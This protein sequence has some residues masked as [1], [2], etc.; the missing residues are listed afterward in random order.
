MVCP[1]ENNKLKLATS[2]TNQASQQQYLN[3]AM[4]ET[5]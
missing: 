2:R 3:H 1:P 5:L 4:V